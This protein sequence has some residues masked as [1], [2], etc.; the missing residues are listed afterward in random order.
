[1]KVVKWVPRLLALLPLAVVIEALFRA[2]DIIETED[3]TLL[4]IQVIAT[5]ALG[6]MLIIFFRNRQ[7]I[8]KRM[9]I[10]FAPA[11]I[12]YSTNKVSLSQLL[13]SRATRIAFSLIIVTMGLVILPFFFFLKQGYARMMQPAVVLLAGFIFLTILLTIIVIFIN[14]RRSPFFIVA[15]A[16]VIIAST[17]NNNNS[18]RTVP[19]TAPIERMTLKNNFSQWIGARRNADSVYPLILVAAEGG[20]IRGAA[21]TS[22]V[23]KKLQELNPAFIDHVY[24]ISGVSGGGVGSVFYTAYLR[25]SLNK[26]FDNFPS[27]AGRL[28]D[29]VSEDFLSDLTAAF[30]FHDNFQRLLPFPVENFSR[31]RKLEDSWGWSY[32]KYLMSTTLSD[33]FLKIWSDT[34]DT[35][36]PNLFINGLLAETGQKTIVSNLVFQADSNRSFRDDIDVLGILGSDIPLKTAASLCSRFPVITSGA[37]LKKD[38]KDPKGHILD[39]GYKENSGIETA[40]QLSLALEPLIRDAEQRL[41]KKIPVYLLFIQNSTDGISFND[42]D[43]KATRIVPDLSTIIPGFLNAWDRRTNTHKNISRELFNESPMKDR[44]RYFEIRLTNNRQLLPLGWYLSEEAKKNII[45]QVNK[46]NP[47]EPV[48]KALG[49]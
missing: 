23:L 16:Y 35:H 15:A 9:G 32:E 30:L 19:S 3:R 49:N 18:I 38:N 8:A 47:N 31:N 39:G 12:R 26:Q 33:P 11:N 6:V 17:C 13:E 25:D 44:L 48:L 46:I 22:L 7:A 34:T 20:G 28:E 21:W 37:L 45:G 10:A 14:V 43:Q 29:A 5:L 36:I 40:W 42:P 24:A 2:A 4:L 41:H 27:S 1:M